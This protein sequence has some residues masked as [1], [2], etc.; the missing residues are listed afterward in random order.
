MIIPCWYEHEEIARS[1]ESQLDGYGT[2]EG[3]HCT[4]LTT[5][6]SLFL[7]AYLARRSGALMYLSV[8]YFS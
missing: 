1:S 5:L 8:E 4:I 2:R 7:I 3:I 6:F